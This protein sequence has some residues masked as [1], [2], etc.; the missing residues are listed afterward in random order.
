MENGVAVVATGVASTTGISGSS[1][2]CP[3]FRM[4]EKM[5]TLDEAPKTEINGATNRRTL[6]I[7][8]CRFE[9]QNFEIDTNSK[10]IN[11]RTKTTN[12]RI[13]YFLIDSLCFLFDH[14]FFL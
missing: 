7:D 14:L 11:D 10:F 5:K 8:F 6:S 12:D 9:T 2:C 1:F 4:Q 3:E 13:K